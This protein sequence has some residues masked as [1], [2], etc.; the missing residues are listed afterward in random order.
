MKSMQPT[1]KTKML[2]H[3]SKI[4]LDVKILFG[5]ITQLLEPEIGKCSKRALYEWQGSTFH[6]GL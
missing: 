1:L 2:I 6:S 5:K 3:R 4:N